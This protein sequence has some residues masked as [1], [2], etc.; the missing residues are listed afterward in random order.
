MLALAR[1]LAVPVGGYEHAGHPVQQ[2]ALAEVLAATGLAADA[3]A[4]AGDG[5]RAPT[6]WLPLLAM[7]RAWARLA[8]D[9]DD[10]LVRLRRAMVAHPE[11]V[12][13][14]ERAC[15]QFLAGAGG[16]VVVKVGAEGVYC[17]ALPECRLG[18]ALKVDS[19]DGRCAPVALGAV[20][21]QL[22]E[23]LGLRL[24]HERWQ[25]VA[26]PAVKDTRGDVVGVVAVRGSL[27]F[28]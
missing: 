10:V 28:A 13:G 1:H 2:Q 20:V 9:D 4:L 3:V 22:D 5:C 18:V 23:R 26:C 17:A 14:A 27:T 21:R 16:R 12:A 19:G 7:A 15:T 8:S 24:P 25:T 6:F 11:L